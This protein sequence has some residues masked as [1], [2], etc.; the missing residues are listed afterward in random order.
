MKA[1]LYFSE[2]EHNGDLDE[3]LSDIRNCGGKILDSKIN[4]EAETAK[5]EIEIDET[6]AEKFRNTRACG[7]SNLAN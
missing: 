2:C 5:V 4:Y 1:V 6:F 3:Y 7:Y